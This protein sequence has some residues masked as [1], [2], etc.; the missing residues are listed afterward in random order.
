MRM[1]ETVLWRVASNLVNAYESEHSNTLQLVTIDGND[2]APAVV[3]DLLPCASSGYT[4]IC[5]KTRLHT[6]VY[7]QPKTIEDEELPAD[8]LKRVNET[9]KMSSFECNESASFRRWTKMDAKV[10]E[11]DATKI[12]GRLELHQQAIPTPYGTAK[13][14]ETFSDQSIA[15]HIIKGDGVFDN[16]VVHVYTKGLETDYGL[17]T[18]TVTNADGRVDLGKIDGTK[19]HEY[20][21]PKEEWYGKVNVE[22]TMADGTTFYYLTDGATVEYYENPLKL[23]ISMPN[24][25]VKEADVST[26]WRSN[27][28]ASRSMIDR[29]KGIG[30][31]QQDGESGA[32]S[33][34][35]R[36]EYI[37]A[38]G[39]I[40]EHDF[41][42]D[43]ISVKETALDNSTHLYSSPSVV[44]CQVGL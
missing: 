40:I 42:P 14:I 13:L 5:P 44:L 10:D 12:W 8:V 25:T 21:Q 27:G 11:D 16:V 2:N 7:E 37:L 1:E 15:Y 39:S 35:N 18:S 26:V 30:S 29:F 23:R 6:W 33:A 20:A 24:G 31:E 28:K 38:D 43:R 9:T 19:A 41:L 3:P 32:N 34:T 17:V 4:G 22:D 36:S